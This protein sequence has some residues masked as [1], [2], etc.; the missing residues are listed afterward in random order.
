MTKRIEDMNA[1]LDAAAARADRP[2]VRFFRVQ[3]LVDRYC[4]GDLDV[5]TPDGSHY[6]PELH[7]Q[8]GRALADEIEAWAGTQPHLTPA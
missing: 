4:D 3:P 1:A 8:I 2:N 5:A 6:S 7:R